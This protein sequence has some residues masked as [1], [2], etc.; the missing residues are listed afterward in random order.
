M[1]LPQKRDGTV[2]LE[3]ANTEGYE[4]TRK[5]VKEAGGIPRFLLTAP[6]APHY[7][8]HIFQ[9]LHDCYYLRGYAD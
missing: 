1:S 2:D 9:P 6:S 3:S 5:T 4:G 8:V 7:N